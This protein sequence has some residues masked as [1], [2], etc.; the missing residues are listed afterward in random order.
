M[1]VEAV[2]WITPLHA[3]GQPEHLPQPIGD[4]FLDFRH[5]RARLPG[6][7]DHAEAGADEIAKNAGGQRIGR[8]IAEE[9]RMLPKRK[10]GQDDPIQIGDDLAEVFRL[11]RRRGRQCV[12]DLAGPG[13]G[14]HRPLRQALV[15]VGQPVDELVAITT[16]FLR[17]HANPRGSGGK[18]SRHS[19]HHARATTVNRANGEVRPNARG[20]VPHGWSS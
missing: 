15:V 3:G 6:E 9:A 8:E 5:R 19:L 7:P 10:S 2:S 11:V 17:C 16:E 13:S 4:H 20:Q 1:L 12:A 18:W 14:H